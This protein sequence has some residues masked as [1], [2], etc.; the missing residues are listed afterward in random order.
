ME[1]IIFAVETSCDE[2]ACALYG[3]KSGLLGERLYSQWRRHAAYGGVVPEL[4]SRDHLRRLLPL[5]DEL[6]RRAGARPTL[7]AYTRGPGLAGALLAG[8]A[9]AQTL[10]VAWRLPVVGVNHLEGHLLSP[11]L[12]RV[13]PDFPYVAL[14]V[15]GGHSQLWLVRGRG[16]YFLLG[17]TFD[18]S[19]GE[20]FDK[21]AVLLGL[22]YPGGAA[23]EKLAATSTGGGDARLPSPAQR[24]FDFSFSGVKDGGGAACRCASAGRYCRRFSAGGGGGAG[25]TGKK[26]AAPRRHVKIGGG[27]RRRAKRICCGAAARCGGKLRRHIVASAVAALR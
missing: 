11:L 22:K 18:D 21:V 8:A 15:S 3:T 6:L 14:L 17:E 23:L 19:A 4:A 13:P 10:A 27:R 12:L 7:V 5:C 9:T 26:R 2:T 1:K 24:E 20:A 16:R 25:A